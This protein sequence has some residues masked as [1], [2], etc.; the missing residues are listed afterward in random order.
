[1]ISPTV[2]HIVFASLSAV[3][4]Y[5]LA[6]EFHTTPKETSKHTTCHIR[7]AAYFFAMV[8][9]LFCSSLSSLSLMTDGTFNTEKWLAIVTLLF[10]LVPIMVV[11]ALQINSRRAIINI[12]PS[13]L[14]VWLL[15]FL[16]DGTLRS[17]WLVCLDYCN[18][19][20][21]TVRWVSSQLSTSYVCSFIVW[22]FSPT[23]QQ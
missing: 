18:A 3:C 10:L 14:F 12:N 8:G 23:K 7:N 17:G 1:M 22:V 9:C 2:V 19:T 16:I 13:W 15:I 21:N 4:C 11:I 6:I 20:A 5:F